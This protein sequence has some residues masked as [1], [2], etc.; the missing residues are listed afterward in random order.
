MAIKRY[1]ATLD[2]TITN[3]FE[4]N[5]STRGTGSN[6]GASDVLETFVIHGQTTASIS[7]EN[8]EEARILVQFP[9]NEISNDKDSGVIPS[10]SVKYIF[11]LFNAPH[12]DTTPR[13]FTLDI[14][15]ISKAWSEGTGLDMDE[16]TDMG[17]SNWISASNTAGWE[18]EGGDVH[19]SPAY[20]ASFDTGLENIEVD[21]TTLVDQW[22][23]NTKV[24]YGLL[25]KHLDTSISGTNGS[26]FT[27]KFFGRNSQYFNYRPVIEARWDSA[28]KDN[29]SN[30]LLS[31][32]LLQE[33][34][35]INTLYFYNRVRGQLKNIPAVGDGEIY[36][37]VFT[38]SNSSG[39]PEGT[40][41]NVI[42]QSPDASPLDTVATGGLL[43]ENGV[44]ITGVYTCSFACTNTTSTLFDVWFKDDTYHTG[45]FSPVSATGS[46]YDRVQEYTTKITNLKSSYTRNEKPRLRLFTREKNW[47]PNVYTKVVAEKKPEII[48]D[49]YYSVY[50][51]TDKLNVIPFGTGSADISNEHTKLSYDVS[52]NY[53]D[54]DMSMLE[55]D[56]GYGIRIAY[57]LQDEYQ[58]QREI[59]K[60]RVERDRE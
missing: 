47:N 30:F 17:T 32:S 2:N 51:L 16:Y 14:K 55:E 45:S 19:D 5:L 38:S 34:D 60:F 31:S 7:A 20:T 56:Y 49:A 21:I 9:V 1:F 15:A 18:N 46:S 29:R 35:N 6:M 25:I 59:F 52:G 36:V 22:V 4:K 11:K 53:F 8:A 42:N 44:A 37:S 39:V 23:N 50:R 13:N 54:L 48:E 43:V 27:K 26:L 12:A 28:R 57:Y 41:I 24:N 10:S 33:S 58:V 3:A 40:A